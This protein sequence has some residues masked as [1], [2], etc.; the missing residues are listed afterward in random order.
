MD[1]K[2]IV[3][4]IDGI[5]YKVKTTVSFALIRIILN[6]E[7]GYEKLFEK[8]VAEA[9]L[10]AIQ[11]EN[12]ENGPSVE[13]VLEAGNHVFQQFIDGVIG[14]DEKYS[15]Y[16]N[17]RPGAEPTCERFCNALDDYIHEIM[18]ETSKKVADI[19]VQTYQPL[20]ETFGSIGDM[21]LKAY[22][23]EVLISKQFAGI[24]QMV[25]QFA[26]NISQSIAPVLENITRMQKE[27]GEALM[28]WND[29]DWKAVELSYSKWGQYGWTSIG[30]APFSFFS[31]QPTSQI[32]ADKQAMQFFNNNG[33]K[34]LFDDLRKLKI[35][36]QD[37]E[38][39]IFCFETKQYKACAMLLCAIVEA[40]L[41]RI[42]STNQRRKVGR[43]AVKSFNDRFIAAESSETSKLLFLH[44]VNVLSFLKL[45][46]DDANDFRSE[47]KNLNRNFINHGMA[48]RD[49]RRK[50]CVKLFLGLNNIIEM[51]ELYGEY[52]T[53]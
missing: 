14:S 47:P 7:Q 50:D 27:L 32:D 42:Q 36:K 19:L 38:S 45:L 26:V 35:N 37:L 10:S 49:V 18:A 24:V 41:I 13:K 34:I 16:Y 21:L 4:E 23:P 12:I 28:A 30:H 40:I 17:N 46:F 6:R 53:K 1:K 20:T 2:S 29:T 33:I 51:L 15:T 3:L 25:N 9:I 48:K 8:R 39:A 22:E 43:G 11:L 52:K 44:T 31:I 5:E